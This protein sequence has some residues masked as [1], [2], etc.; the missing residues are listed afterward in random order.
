MPQIIDTRAICK[1]PNRYIGWPTIGRSADGTLHVVFSG[2]RDSH[3]CPFGKGF[4]LSSTDSGESWG[5]AK[6]VN[7]TPMDDR[8]TGLCV[9]PDGTLVM[10][11]F[12]SYYYRSYEIMQHGY[13]ESSKFDHIQPWSEWEQEAK[14]A[15]PDD[16]D[17]W[18][19]F[20]LGPT[21]A[22]AT[23]WANA[24]VEMGC[25]SAIDYDD[26]FAANTRRLGYWTR[27]SHDGGQTWD[28]PTL[29]PFCAPHGPN[30]LPNGDLI[31]I[32]T[33]I[34]WSGNVG[35]ATSPDQGLTWKTLAMIDSTTEPVDGEAGRLCEPHVV[36]AQSG[37]LIGVAR[38]QS[39][40]PGE[41]RNVWQFDSADGGQTWS[42]PRPTSVNGYP[43]HLLS[44]SDGRLLCSV[45][46]RHEPQGHRFVF[47]HDEGETWDADDALFVPAPLKDSDLGYPATAEV[48]PGTFVSVYY[49]KEAQG[50]KTC[51][52]MT[53]WKG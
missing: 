42:K 11:W 50:E 36:A 9:M 4:L 19:P 32:G 18:T 48:E 51:L 26:R 49:A 25:E 35:I 33:D 7:N 37:K 14:R 15:T 10:T 44:V 16:L 39:K 23:K 46:V 52:M 27:R 17:K 40:L 1:Q 2:D 22:L 24:W 31:Y 21:E 3:I 34:T 5:E 13:Q 30:L 12:T 28:D 53:R 6:I 20:I 8:D 38:Y 29:S 43:P 47:S 45:G 41:K